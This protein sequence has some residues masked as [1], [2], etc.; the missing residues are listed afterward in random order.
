MT[1]F[2]N[3]ASI[4]G[5]PRF[6]GEEELP[7]NTTCGEIDAIAKEVNFGH[8]LE[9]PTA[10]GS[11]MYITRSCLNDVGEF[12]QKTFPGYGEEND[13]SMRA[14]LKSWKNLMAADT[15]VYHK[16]A[17]SFASQ[18]ETRKAIALRKLQ[19]LYPTYD[20][21][22]H[23]FIRLDPG[24]VFRNRIDFK[25]LRRSKKPVILAIMHDGT[26]GTERHVL[27]LM[28][29]LE[30]DAHWFLLKGHHAGAQLQWRDPGEG[31]RIGYDWAGDFDE[32]VRFLKECNLT[33]VHVH[34]THQFVKQVR[35]LVEALGVPFDFTAHDY[36]TI[37]PQ[38][39]LTDFTGAYCG[40]PDEAGCNKCLTYL[41]IT[42]VPNI[43]SWRKDHQ[44]L[45]RQADRVFAP[46]VDAE[47]RLNKYF[48][49]VHILSTPPIDKHLDSISE[50][51]AIALA[52]QEKLRIAVI[53]AVSEA[54]GADLLQLAAI[55]ARAR[56][57]PI[58]FHLI[59]HA[60]RP[61]LGRPKANLMVYG[62]YKQEDLNDMI[63]QVNPHLA[64]FPAVC[65]ETYCY[66]LSSCIEVGLPVVAPDLGAFPE[67]LRARPWSWIVPWE[68]EVGQW[69]DLFSRIADEHFKTGLPPDC[70]ESTE[71]HI[72]KEK[73]SYELD[74]LKLDLAK[75]KRDQATV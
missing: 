64:W 42:G 37:C 46:S 60:Y 73:F 26:G 63:S 16:G 67:R 21:I 13:F 5:Y 23:G 57:L 41:P 52:P 11:C 32:L 31:L 71:H 6:L 12:D 36:S 54:K 25:R 20:E 50:A 28:E 29:K 59:G 18:S 19:H 2:S 72:E 10:V 15:F 3:N 47:T 38:V 40:E 7:Q 56:N 22:V 33:R 62:Q 55:D 51:K 17:V 30:S 1:P 27:D 53:G 68:Q 70:I 4:C 8:S 43:S 35:K 58:E 9:I 49:D 45:L 61:L 66:A 69:N 34:H 74:Y 44:W 65:P 75:R 24:T 14:M 39:T 48:P